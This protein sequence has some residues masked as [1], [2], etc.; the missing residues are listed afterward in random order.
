MVV[1]GRVSGAINLDKLVERR[2]KPAGRPDTLAFGSFRA[3]ARWIKHEH[4]IGHSFGLTVA[5]VFDQ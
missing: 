2:D 1:A 5:A 3:R 4:Q